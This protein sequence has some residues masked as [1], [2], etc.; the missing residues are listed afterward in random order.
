MK[1]KSSRH[2]RGSQSSSSSTKLRL[3]EAKARAALEL[4]ARF[5]KEKQTL[6]MASKDLELDEEQNI[7]GMN[8][9]LE[10]VKAK[11]TAT[12]CLPEAKPNNQTTLRVPFGSTVATTPPVTA[13]T[14]VTTASVN[15][16]ARPFV[17]RSPPIKEEYGT[18]TDTKLSRIKEEECVHKFESDP[19]FVESAKP[20]QSYL[21][22]HRKQ[23]ELTQMIA[24]QQAKSFLPSHQ[25]PTF[26]GDVMSYPAFIAAFETLIESKVDN[27]S[28]LLYFLNQYIS[29]KAKELIRGCL[30]M[31][32]G[33]SY[34]E[35][36]RLLKKHFA[37]P[38]KIASAY[39]AKLSNWPAV[40][41]NDGTGLQEFSTAL[42]QASNAMTG[43]QYMN[44]LNAANV[45]RQLW[46]KLPRYLRSKWTERV[47]KIRNPRQQVASFTD[48]SEFVSQQA[49]LATEP[50]YSEESIS[51]SVDTVD[52][53]HKQNERKPKRGR[54]TNFAT[55]LSTK[56]DIGG[57]S[58]SINCTLCSRAHHLDECAEF[59]KKPLEDR[60]DFIKEK[61]SCFGCYSPEHVAKHCRNKRSCKTCNKRHPTSL[62]DYNQRP[63][64]KNAQHKQSE[65]GKEDQVINANTT[66]W[67]VT[68]AGYVPITGI[69][70][71]WLYHKN[72]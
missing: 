71:I 33:D 50:V 25:P 58:L 66:V 37:D 23:T 41:P 62:H 16:A 47:S 32:S 5:L 17:S 12:P 69:V 24:T 28:E 31:K 52:K 70:P 4:E 6:S 57:N 54:R 27:S 36:R 11:L 67:N 2:S 48:F 19:S 51:R 39:I 65:M 63:E 59:L 56:K 61:G 68:E 43:M 46:E 26:S 1:S 3:I 42:E 40:R 72:N 44:D 45:L 64:R 38:Y 20:D 13:P 15:P 22:I 8:N 21:D 18:P 49:D 14:L 35:A 55:D 29:G 10:G 53:H 34:K 9:Y 30:Q 7:D 60:R